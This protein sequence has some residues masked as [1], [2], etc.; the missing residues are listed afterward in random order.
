M[1]VFNWLDSR[2]P[3]VRW[4]VEMHLTTAA[5]TLGLSSWLE[6]YLGPYGFQLR[7]SLTLRSAIASLHPWR[8]YREAMIIAPL[9]TVS[10]TWSFALLWFYR[11]LLP[12]VP[13]ISL[14]HRRVA[15]LVRV[16]DV[17]ETVSWSD[18]LTLR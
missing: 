13:T 12:F 2:T 6:T 9:R 8:L 5:R 7:P 16:A 3:L 14:K 4:S 11:G 15:S 18:R 17:W 10:L 1:K